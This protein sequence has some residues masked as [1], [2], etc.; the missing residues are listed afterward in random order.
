Y[1][2]FTEIYNNTKGKSKRPI[3]I[4][5]KGMIVK[6]S[7]KKEFSEVFSKHKKHDDNSVIVEID[8]IRIF[9]KRD[10]EDVVGFEEIK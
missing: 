1:P 3:E 10:G 7:P 6:N 9:V 5:V 8:I 2:E 4:I